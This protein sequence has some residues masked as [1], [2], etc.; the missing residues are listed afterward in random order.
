MAQLSSKE[1]ALSGSFWTSIRWAIAVA[2]YTVIGLLFW[3]SIGSNLISIA[4]MVPVDARLEYIVLERKNAGIRDSGGVELKTLYKYQY[5]GKEYTGTHVVL[6]SEWVLNG[7]GLDRSL[8]D[9]FYMLKEMHGSTIKVWVDSDR[10]EISSIE[11][12][13]HKS[14]LWLF[15]AFSLFGLLVVARFNQSLN[16]FFHSVERNA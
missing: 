10:P 5:Q 11:K 1:F 9:L 12:R 3:F 16:R 15:G 2:A 13:I 4:R 14:T 7:I 8:H 6:G